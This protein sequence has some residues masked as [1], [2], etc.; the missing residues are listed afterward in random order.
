MGVVAMKH[1][2]LLREW[3]EKIAECRTSGKSVRGWCTERG[4]GEKRY[5]YWE[6]RVLA[7]AAGEMNLPAAV[8]EC[9]LSRIVHPHEK[10]TSEMR[11]SHLTGN[12]VF[13]LLYDSANFFRTIVKNKGI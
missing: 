7:E 5:Y 13:A 12:N 11:I 1:E 3:R 6:K 4:I 2:A 8:R 10:F 9:R